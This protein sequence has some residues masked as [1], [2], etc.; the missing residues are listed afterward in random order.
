MLFD[1]VPKQ[2]STLGRR[3]VVIGSVKESHFEVNYRAN[4]ISTF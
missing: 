4:I 2:S 3:G 1:L